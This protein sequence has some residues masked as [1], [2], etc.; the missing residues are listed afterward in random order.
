MVVLNT[1]TWVTSAD[2]PNA[3]KNET[4]TKLPSEGSGC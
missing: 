4:S 1:A 3:I 2:T